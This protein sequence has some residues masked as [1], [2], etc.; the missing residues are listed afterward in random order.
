MIVVTFMRQG[1][2]R[3]AE[4][5][6]AADQ[7]RRLVSEWTTDLPGSRGGFPHTPF[8][9]LPGPPKAPATRGHNHQTHR[10]DTKRGRNPT[11][12]A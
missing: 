2:C 7:A 5:P 4:N 11:R 6:A 1:A 9:T 8:L 3:G 10:Q 12:V